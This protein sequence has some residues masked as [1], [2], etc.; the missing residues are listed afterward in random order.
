[1]SKSLK[2]LLND[3]AGQGWFRTLLQFIKFGIVGLSNTAISYGIEMLCYYVLLVNAAWGEGAKVIV[4]SVL[5]FVVSVTNS[6][7]WNNK[8]VFASGRKDWRGHLKSYLKTV[9]C[10]GV[11]GLILSPVVKLLLG[12][13]GVPYW[14][15]SLASL[16]ITIPL[17]FVM[18]KLWAFR[19]DKA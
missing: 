3:H 7:F 14:A 2:E 9:A 18:N 19:T 10:Y 16:I 15:A 5:A 13:W 12:N 17:N 11:T 1:M 6:Y 8:F 4:T